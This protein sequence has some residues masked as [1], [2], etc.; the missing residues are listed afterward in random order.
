M[1]SGRVARE[2]LKMCILTVIAGGG[3]HCCSCGAAGR[4]HGCATQSGKQI[5]S[6]GGFYRQ[7][8]RLG[9]RVLGWGG[10]AEMT[11]GILGNSFSE[12]R[13]KPLDF[14]RRGTARGAVLRLGFPERQGDV[15]AL[16]LVVGPRGSPCR[17]RDTAVSVCSSGAYGRRGLLRARPRGTTSHPP[18]ADI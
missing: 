7:G 9:T 18:G 17:P 13:N 14:L 6:R 4:P 16:I 15:N 10:G 11:P 5:C 12:K 8:P 2:N 1:Q 3:Y